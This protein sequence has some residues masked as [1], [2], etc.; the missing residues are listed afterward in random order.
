MS[1][2]RAWVALAFL[3]PSPLPNAYSQ[4]EAKPAAASPF[5][6][7]L[8]QTRAGAS[9]EPVSKALAEIRQ[10]AITIGL[11]EDGLTAV[12][13]ELKRLAPRYVAFVVPPERIED[14]FVGEVFERA[15]GLNDDPLLDFSYGFIS[16]SRG[17]C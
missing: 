1:P 2:F 17:F 3:C 7:V 8:D 5:I 12:F 9:F 6:I 16:R 4:P 15:T 10:P 11:G 14:N 13:A